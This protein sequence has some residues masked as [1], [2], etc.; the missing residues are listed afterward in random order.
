M[1]ELW[2]VV[3]WYENNSAA[4]FFYYIYI[5]IYYLI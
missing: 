1:D 4:T 5:Y 2:I 3:L